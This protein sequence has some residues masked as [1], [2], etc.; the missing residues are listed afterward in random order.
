[1]NCWS[2]IS[3]RNFELQ[4]VSL[5][6]GLFK[7]SLLF[8]AIFTNFA[9]VISEDDRRGVDSFLPV[10]ISL[11]LG[12]GFVRGL[13]VFGVFSAELLLILAGAGVSVAAAV[14]IWPADS[15]NC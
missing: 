6:L 14:F 9:L 7:S 2:S 1:M 4:L 5:K 15:F 12:R 3:A 13:R 10:F 8:L 11:L